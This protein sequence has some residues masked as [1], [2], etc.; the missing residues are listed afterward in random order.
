VPKDV[1]VYKIDFSVEK[2]TIEIY[3]SNSLMQ[4]NK[5]EVNNKYNK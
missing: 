3:Y 5:K 1:P 2:N 4:I